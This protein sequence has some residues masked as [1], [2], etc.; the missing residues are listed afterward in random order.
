[1]M[2]SREDTATVEEATGTEH[3]TGVSEVGTVNAAN[4]GK[5]PALEEESLE[6]R[7]K[8]EHTFLMKLRQKI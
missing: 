7:N 3:V 2:T 4:T 1:M 8:K 5:T 6:H